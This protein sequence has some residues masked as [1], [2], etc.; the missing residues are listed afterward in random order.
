MGKRKFLQ[1]RV[2]GKLDSNMQKNGPKKIGPISYTI[3]K[4]ILKWIHDLNGRLD[5]TK[6]LEESI[7]SNFPDIGYSNCFLDISP[8]T[9]EPK[10]TLPRL[11]QNRNLLHSKGNK[12]TKLKDKLPNGRGIGK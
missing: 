7:G 5:T 12:S 3:H 2:L 4:N 9:N 11:H 6:I 8:E 1:Q 10:N